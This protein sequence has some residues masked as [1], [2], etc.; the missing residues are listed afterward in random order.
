MRKQKQQFAPKHMTTA[1]QNHAQKPAVCTSSWLSENHVLLASSNHTGP[2]SVDPQ[3][4]TLDEL[5]DSGRGSTYRDWVEWLAGQM[6][7]LG[8]W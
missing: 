3:G 7:G 2:P 8:C 4:L 5:M 1:Q 6:V